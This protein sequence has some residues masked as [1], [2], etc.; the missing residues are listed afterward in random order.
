M[1]H[2]HIRMVKRIESASSV[3]YDVESFDFHPKHQWE[4]V[5]VVS[6]DKNKEQTAVHLFA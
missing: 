4:V 6:I 1:S 2:F 3:E 5:G